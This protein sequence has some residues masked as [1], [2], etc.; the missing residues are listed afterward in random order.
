M[1][2]VKIPKKSIHIDMT[3]MT[4]VAFLLLTFFMLTTKFKPDEPVVID[5]PS[6]ISDIKLPE[7]DII[8]LNID[9]DGKVFYS[10][11]GKEI[12]ADLLRKMG[13]IYNIAFTPEEIQKF[14][15]LSTFGIPIQQMKQ[16][17]TVAPPDRVNV[18]QPGVPIDSTNNQLGDWIMEGRRANKE[19]SGKDCRVA[20]KGDQEAEYPVVKEVIAT[21]QDKNVNK[22][23]FITTL[24]GRVDE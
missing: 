15:L 20:L 4:D 11:E 3:A 12:R 2:K 8:I 6:S 19:V 22:F 7:S 5:P 18:D 16:F 13:K 1:P 14:S 17:L 24:E 9:K 23:N 10:I 21:L